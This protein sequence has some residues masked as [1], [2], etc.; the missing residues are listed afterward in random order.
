[1][2][3]DAAL[4]GAAP[5][6]GHSEEWL[7]ASDAFGR[8]FATRLGPVTV[9]QAVMIEPAEPSLSSAQLAGRGTLVIGSA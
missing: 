9:G 6:Q 4:T 3:G 2:N 7:A 5:I 8:M 1:M